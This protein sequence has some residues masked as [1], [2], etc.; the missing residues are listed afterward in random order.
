MTTQELKERYLG[1]SFKGRGHF[2]VGFT[3]RGKEYFAITTNTMAIDRIDDEMPER[4]NG[5]Y[6]VTQKQ[7]LGALYGEVLRV[8]NLK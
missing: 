8:N 4:T 2:R 1:S 7:A 6:Y 3:F 5:A